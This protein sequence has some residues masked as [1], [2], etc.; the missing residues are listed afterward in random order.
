[1]ADS[2]NNNIRK[3][4][5]ATGVVTTFAGSATGVGGD[6]DGTG[7]A[8]LLSIPNGITTDGS[9]L[10]T[11][12]AGP[13]ILRKIE[14][15]TQIVTTMVP[16]GCSNTDGIGAAAGFANPMDITTDGTNL[17]VVD[18]S[19]Q[20]VRMVVIATNTVSTLAGAPAAPA[21]GANTSGATDATG[22]A[23]LFYRPQGITTD[24]INL[25]VVDSWNS[26]IRQIVI[27][28]GAVT[29]LAGQT[30]VLGAADGA[31]SA[32]TFSNPVGITTDGSSLYVTDQ[33]NNTIRKIQ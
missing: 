8:A 11:V 33:S 2:S 14:I 15:A 29:T 19:S 20:N 16:G 32:A 25:Y 22:T 27:A 5:I 24:G 10:Y 28:T 21:A 12:E 31:G 9:F 13:C 7:T 6:L 1:V 26:T 3:I 17:Y 4:V 18:N 30:G 23:A